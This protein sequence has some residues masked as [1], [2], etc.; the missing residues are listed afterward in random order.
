MKPKHPLTIVL[1]VVVSL[2]IGGIS[3]MQ[4]LRTEV[5]LVDGG[6]EE[7]IVTFSNNIESFIKEQ[8]LALRPL[9][10]V[11]PSEETH[12]SEGLRI[13]IKR[14]KPILVRVGDKE[15]EVYERHL[16]AKD[17]LRRAGV[18][19]GVND[20]L[21]VSLDRMIK[22]GE[23]ISVN[24]EEK[25]V[26]TVDRE[27]PFKNNTLPNKDLD[28]GERRI[29]QFGAMGTNREFYEIT[30]LGNREVARVL[31]KTEVVAAPIDQIMYVG[32]AYKPP[33]VT[34]TT[35][36]AQNNGTT[37]AKFTAMSPRSATAA[38]GK[39]TA[40]ANAMATSSQLMTTRSK[41]FAYKNSY[42]MIATAYDL[43]YASTGKLPGMKDY[44]ITASGTKAR[45]GAVA[46][47]PKVIPLGTKLYI[48]YADGTG[49]YGYATAEDT[50]SAIKGY[51]VDLFFNTYQECIEF[52]R[53]RVIV[54][55]IE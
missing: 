6:K 43:S 10:E 45:V 24:K 37:G 47:D 29:E 12:L 39:N 41:D 46:V 36:V 14:F 34:T 50:G 55:V 3:I 49:G 44:G 1:T 33:K 35:Q 13:V 30:R 17:V 8:S 23:V 11:Y 53:R 15:I 21:S 25:S 54:Y 7:K 18:M 9:D 27:V 32:P 40:N 16:T 42:V 5:V 28:P 51:R 48:E 22:S 52:G 20:Q 26:V 38:G 19:I 4:L 31:V 2:L